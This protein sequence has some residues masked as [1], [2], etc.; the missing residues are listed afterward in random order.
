MMSS[1]S[2][3]PFLHTAYPLGNPMSW[4]MKKKMDQ[5][6]KGWALCCKTAYTYGNKVDFNFSAKSINPYFA[7]YSDFPHFKF[8]G[9]FSQSWSYLTSTPEELCC[10]KAAADSTWHRLLRGMGISSS[11]QA[12]RKV[13]PKGKEEDASALEC[14]STGYMTPLKRIWRYCEWAWTG[15]S[16]S[17]VLSHCSRPSASCLRTL[18]S[19]PSQTW[20]F[21]SEE[22]RD[23]SYYCF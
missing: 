13:G 22:K 15:S 16:A 3:Y 12:L 20:W 4:L 19:L 8:K 1:L 6:V 11:P 17:A 9:H 10:P 7:H 23:Y 18:C 5:K 2:V 21:Y 14:N